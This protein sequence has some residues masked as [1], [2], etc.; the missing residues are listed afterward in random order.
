K[1]RTVPIDSVTL[2]DD[3]D[4][5][6]TTEKNVEFE[7]VTQAMKQLTAEQREVISLRFFGGLTS[8]EVGV[9]LNKGDGAVR[10]MQRAAMEKLRGIMGVE[11]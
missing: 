3:D 2:Q 4:P 1:R 7:Q 10:E 6:D 5:A 9:I 11:C 8:K